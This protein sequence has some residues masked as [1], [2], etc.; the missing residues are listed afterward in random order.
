[1]P[2]HTLAGP[3]TCEGV[4]IHSGARAHL[5]ASAAAPGHGL[6]FVRVDLEGAP[7]IPVTRPALAGASFATHLAAPGRTDVGVSTVEHLL[8]A[9]TAAGVDDARLEVDGPELPIGDGS[10]AA[11]AAEIGRVGRRAQAGDRPEI[12]LD[13]PIEIVDG[14]RR[15]QARPAD[16][17]GI[18]VAI[19]FD[20]PAIGRQRIACAAFD[21]DWFARELAPARTFGFL[22]DVEALRAADRAGGASL[23][24][25]V[26]FDEAGVANR[27][28]LRFD[29]EPVRHKALDLVGDL[30]LLGAPLR[31]HV[32][33]ERGGHAL[34]HRLVR[35]I[36]ESTRVS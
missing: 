35:A 23:D 36:D 25:T 32:E 17:F 3:F 1:M 30:A 34:H 4:A 22:A 33:V 12:V 15:I 14:N 24:N 29:D 5:V 26:V 11:F 16:V 28:G 9:L 7:E 20:H 10:A 18:D 31:A 6:R 8:A 19:D 27:E 2:R 21:F 13:G